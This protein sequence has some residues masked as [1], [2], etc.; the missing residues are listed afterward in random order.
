M[1]QALFI[2]Q[3]FPG[4][5]RHLAPAIAARPGARV[6]GLGERANIS[7]PGVTHIRY[8]E[9]HGAGDRTHHYLRP[10]EAAVRRAQQVARA[11]MDLKRE[12]F[13]PDIICCHPGWG[14]GLFVADIFPSAKQL[15]YCEFHFTSAGGDVGF[16]PAYPVALDEAARTRLLNLPQTPALEAMDWGVSPT[17]FQRGRYPEV[18][19][20]KI[21]VVHE[22]VDRDLASPRGPHHVKLPNGR[23]IQ[24]GDEVI[25]Y[26]SRN[27][28][29]YRGFDVFMR[30]LPEILARRP[31]AQVVLVGGEAR[32][33]GPKPAD[34]RSWRAHL[35]EELDGKLDLTRVHF[36]GRI[37]HPALLALFRLSRAHI[38]LTY[39]YV[40]SW[41]MIEAMGCEA[42]VI[43]SAT[44]PV[45]EVIAHGVNGLLVPFYDTAALA[46][47]VV[48]ALAK[49]EQ[50]EPIRKAARRTLLERYDL[51]TICLPQQ[52]KLFDAVLEGRPGDHV[53]PKAL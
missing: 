36:T 25:T 41:S 42:L 19:R 44:P 28:E 39:P 8:P 27:L 50:Y 17:E 26:V 3:N 34:G 35:L 9:P 14:E 53:I 16:N 30:A 47:T 12:G 51:N 29:P 43:G 31:Q 33:Y 48:Q 37:P 4:Q 38:Y 6:I 52:I 18:F 5:Y 24:R 23:V 40:L 15:H 21:S 11:L 20:R 2:H 32:G 1:V 13:R 7:L 45:Q 22:G 49:P 10:M 46:E